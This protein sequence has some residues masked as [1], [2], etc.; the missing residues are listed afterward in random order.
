[1]TVI[2]TTVRPRIGDHSTRSQESQ[3][4][5]IVPAPQ[6]EMLNC[7]WHEK[8]KILIRREGPNVFKFHATTDDFGRVLFWECWN[9]NLEQYVTVDAVEHPE[10]VRLLDSALAHQRKI[11]ADERLAAAEGAVNRTLTKQELA[12]IVARNVHG[13]KVLR[14]VICGDDAEQAAVADPASFNPKF[15]RTGFRPVALVFL[16]GDSLGH[17]LLPGD[18]VLADRAAV[19]IESRARRKWSSIGRAKVTRE[20]LDGTLFD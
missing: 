17:V 15:L 12:E 9:R 11:V 18:P 16:K 2:P 10:T 3:A 1:M 5:P 4:P 8:Q 13:A 14:L 6:G 7:E 20:I 19:F